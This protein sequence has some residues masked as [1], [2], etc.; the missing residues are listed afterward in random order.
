MPEKMNWIL[1]RM[2]EALDRFFRPALEAFAEFPRAVSQ[3][4]LRVAAVALAWLVGVMAFFFPKHPDWLVIPIAVAPLGVGIVHGAAF[5]RDT[6]AIVA[7]IV[8]AV[9]ALAFF[10]ESD[11]LGGGQALA[12][13]PPGT[14]IDA[15]TGETAVDVQRS[16]PQDAQIEGGSIFRACNR[17]TEHPCG[18]DGSQG[19]VRVRPGDLIELGV[20][21]HTGG[22]YSVP[23]ARLVVALWGGGA[24][25]ER[26]VPMTAKL[27]IEYHTGFSGNGIEAQAQL[28]LLEGRG[29]LDLNYVPGST[30]LLD[31]HHNFLTRLP[32]G[33]MDNG[34]GL[35]NVGSPSSCYF[36]DI[37][38]T[39]F[40]F[41]RARMN[42]GAP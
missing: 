27:H 29:F 7:L 15:Q 40:V 11:V 33:I 18:W 26:P 20:L 5:R 36:C 10:I 8:V 6:V 31:R 24:T 13:P 1:L 9:G 30:I 28:E 19:P 23:Y 37:R 42:D 3:A 38:Y 32:D 4:N 39:R 16:T 35:A 22:D 2:V 17:T 25:S 21:L 41:F 14:V 34:I 12:I